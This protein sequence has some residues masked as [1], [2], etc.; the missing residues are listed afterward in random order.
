MPSDY[1]G[2]L[3]VFQKSL[4]MKMYWS[5]RKAGKPKPLMVRGERERNLR[6]TRKIDRRICWAR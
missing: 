5:T 2:D 6:T 3:Q 4:N 1:V